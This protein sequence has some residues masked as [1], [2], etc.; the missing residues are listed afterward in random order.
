MRLAS[1]TERAR[2]LAILAL[3]RPSPDERG[4]A[5]ATKREDDVE[6]LFALIQRFGSLAH[7][8]AVAERHAEFARREMASCSEWISPSTHR[9]FL[10]D[11]IEFVRVRDD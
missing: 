8:S 2:A 3:P 11:I 9:E 4:E 7:A 6:Y 1:E 5:R 10:E